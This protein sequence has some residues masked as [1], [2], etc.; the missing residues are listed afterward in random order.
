MLGDPNIFNITSFP[1]AV[2]NYKKIFYLTSKAIA[3][4]LPGSEEN[5]MIISALEFNP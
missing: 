2:N 1:Y 5:Q 3:I 4:F